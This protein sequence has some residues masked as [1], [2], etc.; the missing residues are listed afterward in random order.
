MV[1]SN[2]P[3]V[4]DFPWRLLFICL[5]VIWNKCFLSIEFFFCGFHCL[6]MFEFCSRLSSYCLAVY[7]DS[8][9]CYYTFFI[10]ISI[11]SSET[12]GKGSLLMLWRYYV[13]LFIPITNSNSYGRVWTPNIF[14]SSPN[15]KTSK[16]LTQQTF[17]LFKVNTKKR[18]EIWSKLSIK[19]PE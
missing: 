19:T 18:C 3:K 12:N 2:L 1:I 8:K 5:S 14:P 9:D 15:F 13:R 10:N 4:N 11:V 16:L 7:G 6:W 17:Y